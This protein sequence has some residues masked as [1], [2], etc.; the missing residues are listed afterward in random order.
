MK[1]KT[2]VTQASGQNYP[3]HYKIWGNDNA[4]ETLVCVHGLTGNSADF[5]FVGETL[6]H[7]DYKVIAI[8]MAG[9]GHSDY[10]LNPNDYNFEQYLYDLNLLLDEI[11][12]NTPQSCDWLGVSMGGL[13]GIRLAGQT[14]SPIRNLILS[15]IGPEVPQFDLDFIAKVI[16]LTPEYDSPADV[17]P[18]LKMALGTPYSRGNMTDDQW[19]YFA[20]IALKKSE[21][22]K[23][24]KNYDGQIIHKFLTEPLGKENLWDYW[25]NIQQPTLAIRGGLSTLFPVIIADTMKV[26]KPD[27]LLDI[28]TIPDCGHVPSLFRDDQIRIL[29]DWLMSQTG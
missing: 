5:K 14:A 9:R 27:D 24:I 23:F 1:Q 12:C 26:R 3:L 20:T 4:R 17:I 19:L 8:D 16:Q 28:V 18:F 13:L 21:S 11:G 2:L 25:D 7:H 10:Y 15:D 6:C 29:S 22:G